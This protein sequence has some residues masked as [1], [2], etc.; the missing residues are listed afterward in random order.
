MA[1]KKLF[2]DTGGKMHFIPPKMLKSNKGPN[3]AF[4]REGLVDYIAK[5]KRRLSGKPYLFQFSTV[6]LFYILY[7]LCFLGFQL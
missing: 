6:N 5:H 4:S 7:V 2:L 1:T 3:C